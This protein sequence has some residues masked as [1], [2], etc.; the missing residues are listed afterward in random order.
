[1]SAA[2]T[3]RTKSAGKRLVR[4]DEDCC[5]GSM[6]SSGERFSI[7]IGSRVAFRILRGNAAAP[8]RSARRLPGQA[9]LPRVARTPF[10]YR[11]AVAGYRWFIAS[12]DGRGYDFTT[13][14]C[15]KGLAVLGSVLILGFLAL[16]NGWLAYVS[17]HDHPLMA[18]AN[19]ALS[20]LLAL[21]ALILLSERNRLSPGKDRSLSRRSPPRQP[22]P[23]SESARRYPLR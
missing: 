1:M 23:S 10:P 16:L 11:Y 19:G 13:L 9:A 4:R 5:R 2:T 18:F 12:P 22:K 8:G 17:M 6:G 20:L 15:K 14:R 3:S 7:A 21:A